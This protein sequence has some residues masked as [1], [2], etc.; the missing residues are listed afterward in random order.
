MPEKIT[1]HKILVT[2]VEESE[3]AS[4]DAPA[5]TGMCILKPEELKLLSSEGFSDGNVLDGQTIGS[6]LEGYETKSFNRIRAYVMSQNPSEVGINSTSIM[7]A[8]RMNHSLMSPYKIDP[9]KKYHITIKVEEAR[10][11]TLPLP[12]DFPAPYHGP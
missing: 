3:K 4:S 5:V 2:L 11:F 9:A 12:P 1:T 7:K 10:E 8:L 6:L